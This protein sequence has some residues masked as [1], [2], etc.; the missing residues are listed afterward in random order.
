MTCDSCKWW[1]PSGPYRDGYNGSGELWIDDLGGCMSERILDGSPTRRPGEPVKA[2]PDDISTW[3]GQPF[4]CGPKFGCAHW[5]SKAWIP[6][7]EETA[8]MHE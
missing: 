1:K 8:R 3:E 4:Q 7:P 2:K 5:E 6:T